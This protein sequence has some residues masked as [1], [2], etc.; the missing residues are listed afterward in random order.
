MV[1][2][3]PPPPR[4]PPTP[5]FRI[6]PVGF[7]FWR[8]YDPDRFGATAAQFRR[9]GPYLRFDHQ[10]RDARG[11]AGYDAQRGIYYGAET[12]SG[13]VVE[14]FGDSG[15]IECANRRLTLLHVTREVRLLDLRRNGAMRAGSVAAL[16]K[17][18]DRTV[19]Q[20]WSRHFYEHE[21]DYTVIDGIAYL[22]A[23]N[24]EDAIALYER[25]EDAIT[26]VSD[27][28]LDDILIRPYLLQAALDN[29][30]EPPT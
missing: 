6:L 9:H 10:R 1:A 20:D 17:V 5:S 11:G 25:A 21:A 16:A 15:R 26:V 30:L 23:H 12:V 28:R 4:R 18:V 13:C 8:I 7:Q 22:N 24:D 19:S 14:V 29:N 27:I 2:I 3:A